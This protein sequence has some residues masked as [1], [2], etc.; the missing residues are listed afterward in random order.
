M[1]KIDGSED[2]F[3]MFNGT[4]LIGDTCN[5]RIANPS[6]SD[7]NDMMYL[8]VEYFK[9]SKALLVKGSSLQDIRAIYKIKAGQEYTANK[10]INFFLLF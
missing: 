7:L 9:N 5:F 10:G 6:T 3:E 1:P 4:F 2:L 8:R